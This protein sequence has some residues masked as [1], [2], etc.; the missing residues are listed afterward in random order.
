[1]GRD[2]SMILDSLQ[3]TIAIISGTL[4]DSLFG[5]FETAFTEGVRLGQTTEFVEEGMVVDVIDPG[6]V[7]SFGEFGSIGCCG[8]EGGDQSFCAA[9]GREGVD[10]MGAERLK[11]SWQRGLDF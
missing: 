8:R 7:E 1:M 9:K 5:L 6:I 3:D 10:C 2:K 4:A 11:E